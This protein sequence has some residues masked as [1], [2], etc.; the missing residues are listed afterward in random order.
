M[1]SLRSLYGAD[2][3]IF[4]DDNFVGPSSSDRLALHEFCDLLIQSSER[5]TFAIETHP[6]DVQLELFE[7]L[8]LA[9]LGFVAIGFESG[10]DHQLRRMRKASQVVHNHLACSVLK[11][12]R[13]PAY[14]NTILMD[15]GS[16]ISELYET[17]DVLE[18]YSDWFTFN[19]IGHAEARVGT[20]MFDRLRPYLDEKDR[21]R[22]HYQFRDPGLARVADAFLQATSG[23][24][25]L[26][27]DLWRALWFE[28]RAVQRLGSYEIV[29]HSPVRLLV[30]EKNRHT[31]RIAREMI[32]R[33]YPE[34]D[35]T[36]FDSAIV[37]VKQEVREVRRALNE[38]ID[39]VY[40]WIAYLYDLCGL[41]LPQTAPSDSPTTGNIENAM[42]EEVSRA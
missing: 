17:L 13:V 23:L 36:R 21:C 38:R 22:P 28:W 33:V 30:A 40:L 14:L 41:R 10:S 24:Y 4:V 39:L 11:E 34:T 1:L 32:T 31:L 27:Q 19:L 9:G 8:R 6:R 3:F 18:K 12:L 42:V 7:R 2:Q 5:L 16:E 37:D 29:D 25:M 35:K 20:P 15:D 26:T